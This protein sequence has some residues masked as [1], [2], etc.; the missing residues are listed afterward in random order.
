MLGAHPVGVRDDVIAE[1]D[2]LDPYA[3]ECLA[4]HPVAALEDNRPWYDFVEDGFWG[5]DINS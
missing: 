1:A 5:R 2:R 4:G 3:S